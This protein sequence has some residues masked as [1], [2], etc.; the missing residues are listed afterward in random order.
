MLFEIKKLKCAYNSERVV[1]EIDEL[2]IPKGK[3]VF[4]VG[5]SG[6]GKSTILETLGM[7]NNTIQP[8][9][10]TVFNF[11][12][13]EIKPAIPLSTLWTKNDKALSAFRNNFYS[14]IFQNTNLM[15]NLTAYENV[16]ITSLIQGL[17]LSQALP[18]T[19]QVLEDIQLEEITPDSKINELSGGQRQRLAFARAISPQFT[20]LFGDE[21]T[22]NLD[23]NNAENLMELLRNKFKNVAMN[24]SA[25]IV[26]HDMNLALKFADQIIYIEKR[27]EINLKGDKIPYG[28]IDTQNTYE[29]THRTEIW[30]NSTKS[31][32][33][34]ELKSLLFKQLYDIN[35]ID[36]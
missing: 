12:P 11:Y 8:S 29:R 13:D 22:G 23:F 10:D 25:I 21:P 1:L 36:K 16:Y 20:V 5:V 18:H 34:E 3:I 27:F 33:T 24:K 2:I 14:F 9:T 17:S 7:M 30:N 28:Y 31:F 6:V 19:K 35:N 15:N 26:S 4:I 32:S